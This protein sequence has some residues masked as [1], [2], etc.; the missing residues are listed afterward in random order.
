MKR[1]SSQYSHD[2]TECLDQVN[3]IIRQ[4]FTNP[5]NPS[6]T[7]SLSKQLYNVVG[8]KVQYF[9]INPAPRL[10]DERL[11]TLYFLQSSDL[12]TELQREHF[13]LVNNS[14]TSNPM[15]NIIGVTAAINLGSGTFLTPS[16]NMQT[17]LDDST[18]NC[19]EWF[20]KPKNLQHFDWQINSYSPIT[21]SDASYSAEIIICFYCEK[22]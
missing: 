13:Q 4:Q 7:V 20:F 3:V 2:S 6:G 16:G 21:G 18:V 1:D 22:Y 17:K 12:G 9:N 19:I 15:S 8:F 11:G 14:S 10:S 5:A